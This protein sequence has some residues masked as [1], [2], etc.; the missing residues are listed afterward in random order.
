MSDFTFSVLM[1]FYHGDSPS[2]LRQALT[3]LV[4]QS[5]PAS[6][7]V[8]VQDGPV[9][10]SLL[11]VVDGFSC[12][13]LVRLALPDN[14]GLT[15]ALNTGLARC[16][17]PWVARMDSDDIAEPLRFEQ[18]MAYLRAHA[19]IDVLGGQIAEF[20][21]EGE[22]FRLRCVPQEH[23]E[24]LAFMRKRNPVNHMTAIF[25]REAVAAMGGYP[26]LTGMED[27]LLWIRLAAEGRRF[28]NLPDVLVQVRIVNLMLRR[29]GWQQVMSEFRLQRELNTLGLVSMPVAIFH[30][31]LRA[32]ARL[33]PSLWL[34]V[35]YRIFLRNARSGGAC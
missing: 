32:T 12:L 24:I 7:V 5:L 25:R 14:V 8:L 1:A 13:P 27:Y 11:A 9:S 33:L 4:N 6:E 10:A 15:A 21:D 18:Q 28:A 17:Y 29:R 23:A 31:A 34:S 26:E 20:V 2:E 22:A 16:R 3:S 19:D 30:F 35:I